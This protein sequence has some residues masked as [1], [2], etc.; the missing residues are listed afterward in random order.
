MDS[1]NKNFPVGQPDANG[2]YEWMRIRAGGGISSTGDVDIRDGDLEMNGGTIRDALF[3]PPIDCGGCDDLLVPFG[4]VHPLSLEIAVPWV[5]PTTGTTFPPVLFDA[6]DTIAALPLPKDFATLSPPFATF[7]KTTATITI[8]RVG[9]YRIDVS[10]GVT[11]E[12]EFANPATKFSVYVARP[13]L[14]P[15][16]EVITKT[17][18][19]TSGQ[20]ADT[21]WNSHRIFSVD[22]VPYT[23]QLGYT[24][25]DPPPTEAIFIGGNNTLT[26]GKSALTITSI[27][28]GEP[29]PK[30]PA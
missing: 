15:P 26:T 23:L 19:L 17:T 10:L 13:S 16:L 1:I 8:N 20:D 21:V 6:F 11:I 30:I 27:Y 18:A 29:Q 12:D 24:V 5:V 2:N 7:D 4:Q 28:D 3:D 25:I 9:Q 14:S 22:S